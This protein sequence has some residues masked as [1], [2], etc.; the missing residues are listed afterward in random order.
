MSIP[1]PLPYP[2][3][4]ARTYKGYNAA[5]FDVTLERVMHFG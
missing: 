2:Y 1:G 3:R 5:G 4:G